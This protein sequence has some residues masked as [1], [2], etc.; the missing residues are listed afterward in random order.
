MDADGF[1]AMGHTHAGQRV[2]VH[3]HDLAGRNA[4][5]VS[6]RQDGIR[7]GLGLLRRHPHAQDVVGAVASRGSKRVLDPA[8]RLLNHPGERVTFDGG[9]VV[10][11]GDVAIE[12]WEEVVGAHQAQLGQLGR[13]EGAGQEQDIRPAPAK[14]SRASRARRRWACTVRCRPTS[15]G[16]GASAP[17]SSPPVP[18]EFRSHRRRDHGEERLDAADPRT[19]LAGDLDAALEIVGQL[20]QLPVEPRRVGERSK[21]L[22]VSALLHLR[23]RHKGFVDVEEDESLDGIAAGAI[24]RVDLGARN[25]AEHDWFLR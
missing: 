22:V 14:R 5:F 17:A 18:W 4:E 6:E 1:S 2:V 20:D 7:L 9:D 16:R 13:A 24:G 15:P 10:G 12:E 8:L 19:T 3:H 11:D 25:L 23:S 21:P